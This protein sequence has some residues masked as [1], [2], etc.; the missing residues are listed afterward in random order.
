MDI[1]KNYRGDG[2]VNKKKSDLSVILRTKMR[3]S[4]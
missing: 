4:G 1:Y 3:K 2:V